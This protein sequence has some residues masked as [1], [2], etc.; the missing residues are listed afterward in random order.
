MQFNDNQVQ[1]IECGSVG[2]DADDPRNQPMSEFGQALFALCVSVGRAH[3]AGFRAEQELADAAEAA[4]YDEPEM[5]PHE[6]AFRWKLANAGVG[7]RQLE[8]EVAAYNGDCAM[9][10]RADSERA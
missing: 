1:A 10:A 3:A 8:R 5:S 4:S 9:Q 6:A 2:F 7:S